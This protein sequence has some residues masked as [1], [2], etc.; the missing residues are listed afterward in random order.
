MK[1]FKYILLFLVI[2]VGCRNNAGKEQK[3]NIIENKTAL[4]TLE[5]TAEKVFLGKKEITSELTAKITQTY[6][7]GRKKEEIYYI[8]NKNIAK[9]T[10]NDKGN[11]TLVC[12]EAEYENNRDGIVK[13]LH[14]M[15]LGLDDFS[16]D[17]FN[18]DSYVNC[19]I[20]LKE[21]SVLR[22]DMKA[23][24]ALIEFSQRADGALGEV[25]IGVMSEISFKNP[26]IFL[27]TLI[28]FDD[29]TI[30]IVIEHCLSTGEFSDK[31]GDL[32]NINIKKYEYLQKWSKYVVTTNG[33]MKEIGN[34]L[35]KKI[36]Q[37]S[38]PFQNPGGVENK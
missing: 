29:E 19:L 16:W 24:K 38:I 9:V 10:Y 12:V 26:K 22:N 11:E 17:T 6:S 23:L 31:T 25:L 21:Y 2:L 13:L 4:P 15:Y 18:W 28:Q 37:Q 34:K 33:K 5:V 7:D 30:N 20:L 3:T 36:S 35:I 8:D 32:T 27:E 1:K 14:E